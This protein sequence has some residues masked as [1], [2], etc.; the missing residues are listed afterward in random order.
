L[1]SSLISFSRSC[2]LY[3]GFGPFIC[4]LTFLP[5]FTPSYPERIYEMLYLGRVKRLMRQ[6][7][8]IALYF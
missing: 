2:I 1:R 7:I 5:K 4:C 8:P 3:L 6:L